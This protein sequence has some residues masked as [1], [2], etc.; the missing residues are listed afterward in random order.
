MEKRVPGIQCRHS[1]LLPTDNS[2]PIPARETAESSAPDVDSVAAVGLS[3]S[4]PPTPCLSLTLLLGT[5]LLGWGLM[6]PKGVSLGQAAHSL[7]Q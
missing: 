2:E 3:P 4:P 1:E 5:E 7:I 6:A